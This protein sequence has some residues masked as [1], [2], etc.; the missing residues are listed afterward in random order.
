M[1]KNE[2]RATNLEDPDAVARPKLL[3]A[4]ENLYPGC[5]PHE[6]LLQVRKMLDEQH[7]RLRRLFH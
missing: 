2:R 1:K 6:V 5:D 4:I 3:A 7:R